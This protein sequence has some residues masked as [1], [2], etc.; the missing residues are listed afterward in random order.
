MFLKKNIFLLFF[1]V[2]FFTKLFAQDYVLNYEHLTS[3]TGLA[4]N[5]VNCM[6]QE[7][8]GFVW[9]GTQD[10][11]CRYDGNNY[12]VYRTNEEKQTF[13]NSANITCLA[14]END[15][16]IWVGTA[17]GLHRLNTFQKKISPPV[18]FENDIIEDIF[19]DSHQ[20]IWVIVDKKNIY[21]RVKNDI[22]WISFTAKY[23]E[24]Q[25]K[26][27]VKI[28]EQKIG[29]ENQML[30]IEEHT[31][32]ITKTS[33]LYLFNKDD[34]KW[35]KSYYDAYTNIDFIDTSK[36]NT[37]KII[38]SKNRKTSIDTL[39]ISYQDDS[40]VIQEVKIN[41]TENRNVIKN[42]SAQK[43]EEYLYVPL[44]RTV[45]IV[46]AQNYQTVGEINLKELLTVDN[47]IIKDFFIDNSGNIWIGTFGEGI[48]IFPIYGLQKIRS[49]T[50]NPNNPTQGISNSSVRTIYQ[51]PK[52][53]D[54]WIGTY[55]NKQ[56]IDIFIKDSI[57]KE[58]P[59]QSQA[60]IIREDKKKNSILWVATYNGL[61][62]V[63]KEKIVIKNRFLETERVRALLQIDDSTLLFANEDSMYILNSQKDE[64]VYRNNF[65][66][67]TS[68]YMSDDKTIWLGSENEGIFIL[69]IKN[70]TIQKIK[71]YNPHKNEKITNCHVKSIF[72]D[73]KGKFWIATTRGLYLFDRKNETF[74][75]SYT[76]KNGLANNVIYGILEDENYHLWMSTNKGISD[77]DI[78]NKTFENFTV[79]DGLQDDEFNS[80][81]FLKSKDGE[82]FFGGIKGLNAF[83]AK[84]MKR[85]KFIPPIVLTGFKKFGKEVEL[86]IP[87]EKLKKLSLPQDEAQM[88]AFEVAALNFYQ[89]NRNE[90]A[91][92]IGEL[93]KDWVY[94]GT[95]NEVTLTNLAAGNYTLY[96]KASNNHGIW[97]EEGIKIKLNIIPPFWMQNWFIVSCVVT[98][99]ILV[100]SIYKFRIYRIRQREFLLETQIKE[101]TKELAESN[102]SKDQLFAIIAHDLRSPITAFQGISKQINFFLRKNQPERLEQISSSIDSSAQNLN[103]LLNNLLNWSLTE[104]K[105]ISI[106][107]KEISL[108]QNVEETFKV[109]QLIAI[110]SKIELENQVPKS[111]IVFV[112]KDSFQT[113][114]RNLVGNAIKYT[115]ENGKISISAEKIEISENTEE[116]KNQILLKVTDTGIGINEAFK[117]K[118]FQLSVAHS[119]RGIR[120]EKG[121]G[122]G[123]VLCYQFAELN[124]IKIE[125]ESKKDEGTTFLLWIP[126]EQG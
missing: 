16:I 104:T 85:N 12:K 126:V 49:Y 29:K 79:Q 51:D 43:Y 45:L 53:K 69:E 92:R 86:D 62:E 115:P 33:I 35:K 123:L 13:L 102:R 73:S 82:L 114:L 118:L 14:Q 111:T 63:D 90:Y 81:S 93:G 50:V 87:I 120:G 46:D 2:F 67:N 84:D 55:S 108:F 70:N 48:F 24:L 37:P 60:Y 44:Y 71:N 52:T 10:G 109:Y 41:K 116:T 38:I 105:Q 11:L 3:Q 94:L 30:L 125:M 75:A 39:N 83:Y 58:F 121:T 113:I 76:E 21:T 99:L 64:V 98:F 66:K 112:D 119:S 96:I 23:K 80:K 17:A 117:E 1:F 107:K 7:K 110:E 26:D 78:K 57:K 72:E 61:L 95:N 122:L 100:Y 68:L 77:F 124:N 28:T 31:T 97:N 101:R 42:L 65:S 74:I 91:Y 40:F 56:Q 32:G 5:F 27:W 54:T 34:N 9:I 15:S 18:A 22:K 36:V 8:E 47:A 19:I 106:V 6:L 4:N 103:H 59:I 89:N 88:I 20:T 25:N